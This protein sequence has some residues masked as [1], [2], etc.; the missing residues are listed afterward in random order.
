MIRALSKFLIIFFIGFGINTAF[1]CSNTASFNW[2]QYPGPITLCS[3]GVLNINLPDSLSAANMRFNILWSAS[4][5]SGQ[6]DLSP[7]DS[8]QIV[9]GDLSYIYPRNALNVRIS[10]ST[11]KV[12]GYRYPYSISIYN[13]SDNEVTISH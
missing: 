2:G 7:G 9:K 3:Y 4:S 6:I 13:D 10:T 8:V 5:H 1:A 12:S 11:S